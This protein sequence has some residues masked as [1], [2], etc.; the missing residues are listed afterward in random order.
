MEWKV[1]YADWK[2]FKSE[3]RW[4]CSDRRFLTTRSVSLDMK[5]RLEMGR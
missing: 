4:R 2:G 5:D 1:V 3:F